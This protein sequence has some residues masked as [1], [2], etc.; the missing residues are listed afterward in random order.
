MKTYLLK[1]SDG[2]EVIVIGTFDDYVKRFIENEPYPIEMKPKGQ[3][4]SPELAK[5]M[6]ERFDEKHQ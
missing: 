6:W 1:F 2:Y 4:V 5:I 3:T